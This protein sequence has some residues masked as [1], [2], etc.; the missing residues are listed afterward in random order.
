MSKLPPYSKALFQS[1]KKGKIP[2]G[3]IY[4]W[5]GQNGWNI[6]GQLS[7]VFPDK[8]ILLPPWLSPFD[9][10]WPVKLCRILIIDTGYANR[11]YIEELVYC[12]YKNGAE[13]VRFLCPE[14]NLTVF[15]KG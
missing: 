6:A 8:T 9:Y 3:F 1:I 15:K 5:I 2:A 14:F 10:M 7:E 13:E 4:L 12:L 11:D